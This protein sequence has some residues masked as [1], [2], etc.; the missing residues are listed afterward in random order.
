MAL[1]LNRYAGQLLSDT[2]FAGLPGVRSPAGRYSGATVT[3]LNKTGPIGIVNMPSATMTQRSGGGTDISLQLNTKYAGSLGDLK[4]LRVVAEQMVKRLEAQSHGPLRTQQ[5]VQLGHPYGRDKG[6]VPR[7]L[8]KTTS[9]R[10]IGHVKGIRGS[11]P[12][13]TVI[14]EQSPNGL[15]VQWG[16]EITVNTKGVLLTFY[17]DAPYSLYVLAGTRTMQ[18]HGPATYVLVLFRDQLRSAWQTEVRS[19]RLNYLETTN[20]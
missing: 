1:N 20:A 17:N 19:A 10:R 6:G 3:D 7:K 13:L 16:Y 11:V 14:N 4:A 18:A 15:A 2:R 9:G 8:P 5:L 12:D